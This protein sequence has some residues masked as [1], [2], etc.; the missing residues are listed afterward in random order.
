MEGIKVSSSAGD[1]A[2]LAAQNSTVAFT[3]RA[4]I[5]LRLLPSTSRRRIAVLVLK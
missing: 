4:T 1:V 2:Q 5:L 3:L